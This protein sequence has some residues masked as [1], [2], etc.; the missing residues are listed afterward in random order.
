MRRL[1]GS[2]NE[3]HSVSINISYRITMELILDDRQIIPLDIGG[4][5]EVYR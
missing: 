5:D 4:H 1:K 2:L 3:L